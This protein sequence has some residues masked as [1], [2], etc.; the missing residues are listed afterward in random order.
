MSAAPLETL[1]MKRSLSALFAAGLLAAASPASAKQNDDTGWLFAAPDAATETA[2]SGPARGSALLS[3]FDCAVEEAPVA[4]R[5][6]TPSPAAVIDAPVIETVAVISGGV[7]GAT[8][9]GAVIDVTAGPIGLDP[10]P[11]ALIAE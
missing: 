5:S 10:K 1:A 2:S 9:A 7:I 3:L 6:F 4:T 8:P 11:R